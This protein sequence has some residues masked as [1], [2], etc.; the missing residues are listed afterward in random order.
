MLF[1]KFKS[2]YY[3]NLGIYQQQI[4]NVFIIQIIL[5]EVVNQKKVRKIINVNYLLN[6]DGM[7]VQ[8]N[9]KMVL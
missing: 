3:V 1:L 7:K 5:T 4:I 6:M 9:V 8:A 2:V